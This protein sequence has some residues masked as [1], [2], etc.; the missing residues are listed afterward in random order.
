MKGFVIMVDFTVKPGA[1]AAFRALV[2]A[3]ARASCRD[4]TGCRRFDVLAPASAGSRIV[5]YEI[6]DDRAAFAAH[7]ASLHYAAFNRDSAA[8]VAEKRVVE[9]DLVCEGSA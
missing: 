4:E 8:H 5:L 9:Y 6:Y 3:N 2:D 1:M 7:L